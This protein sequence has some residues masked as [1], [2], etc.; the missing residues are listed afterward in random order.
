M[1][2][3]HWYQERED[4]RLD[5]RIESHLRMHIPAT[6]NPFAVSLHNFPEKP[7]Y[8]PRLPSL[9]ETSLP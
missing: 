2:E 3:K 8:I 6:L 7:L 5:D 1:V 4:F 9:D